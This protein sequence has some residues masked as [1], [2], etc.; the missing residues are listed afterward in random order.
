MTKQAFEEL[1]TQMGPCGIACATCDLG[2]GTVAETANTLKQ[3]LQMYEVSTWAPQA[4]GG[5]EIDFNQLGK[6]LDW[7]HTYTRCLGCE[8]GGGP[9]D[10][11]IRACAKERGYDICS[12]CADL[13]ECTKFD[14]LEDYGQQLKNKLKEGRTKKEYLSEALSKAKL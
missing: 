3:Q 14:F 5:S 6:S 12:Q 7:V 13:E 8:Q 1:K 4:P 10:C 9:P 2:N 11:A